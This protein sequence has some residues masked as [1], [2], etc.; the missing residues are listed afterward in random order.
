MKWRHEIGKMKATHLR[1]G[2]VRPELKNNSGKAP[3]KMMG[4]T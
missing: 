4:T 1:E 3:R 2:E